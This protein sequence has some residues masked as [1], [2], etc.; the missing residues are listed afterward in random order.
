VI[1]ADRKWFAR[2]CAGAVLAQTLIDLDPQYPK[3]DAAVR[4]ALTNARRELEAQAPEG[5][6]RDPYAAA[7]DGHGDHR[8]NGHGS[9]H[10]KGKGSKSGAAAGSKA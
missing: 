2:I 6:A 4:R 10:R 3:V 7:H 5:A 1:P 8:S 9:H